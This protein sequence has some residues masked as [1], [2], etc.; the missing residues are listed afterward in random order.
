MNKRDYEVIASVFRLARP[1]VSMN[2]VPDKAW[3]FFRGMF[4]AALKQYPNFDA[5]RFVKETER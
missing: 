5:E 4:V 2:Q 1:A 3:H